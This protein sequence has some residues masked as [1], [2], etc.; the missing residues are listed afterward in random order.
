MP[1]RLCP[2]RATS[3]IV[4]F[5]SLITLVCFENGLATKSDEVAIRGSKAL[6]SQGEAM[7]VTLQAEDPTSMNEVS[8]SLRAVGLSNPF[9][10]SR[11]PITVEVYEGKELV[12]SE[13]FTESLDDEFKEL[14]VPINNI[15]KMDEK[16]KLLIR[17]DTPENREQYHAPIQID[18]ESIEVNDGGDGLEVYGRIKILFPTS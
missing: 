15:P 7:K 6:L 9:A 16:Y 8:F 13:S 10:S 11:I 4:S 1:F 2:S 18:T 12:A 17:Y 14:N 3:I 5:A